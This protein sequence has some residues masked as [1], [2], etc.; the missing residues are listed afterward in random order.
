VKTLDVLRDARERYA[1]QPDHSPYG[2]VPSEGVCVVTACR[3]VGG[4]DASP[5]RALEEA[6]G[7]EV[8]LGRFGKNEQIIRWNAEHSTED[9]LE[10]FDRAIASLEAEATP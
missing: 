10:A 7:I 2:R 8:D 9:V 5:V 4:G 1:R 3:I 6:A